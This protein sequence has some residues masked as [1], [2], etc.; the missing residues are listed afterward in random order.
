VEERQRTESGRQRSARG[1]SANYVGRIFCRDGRKR[2]KGKCKDNH[3]IE[4]I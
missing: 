4:I 3:Y 2:S 1:A